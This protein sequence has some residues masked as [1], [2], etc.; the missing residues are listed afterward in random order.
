MQDVGRVVEDAAEAVAREVAHDR[1]A[2]RLD[3]GLDGVAD[4][5]DTAARLG[6]GDA[7]HHRLVGDVAQPARL[8]ADVAHE[9]HAAGVAVPAVED[10]GDVDIDDVAV[11]QRACRTGCRGRPHG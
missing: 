7:A 8:H 4:V 6:G 11:L 2:L 10:G 3:V 1:E 5:A 9:E